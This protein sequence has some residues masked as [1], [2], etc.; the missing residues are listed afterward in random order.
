MTAFTN[1]QVN[2]ELLTDE[3]GSYI[4]LEQKNDYEDPPT[5]YLHPWQLRATCEHFGII[6]SEQGSANSI[7]SLERLLMT[8]RDRI[9]TLHD[10]LCNNSDHKHA[11]LTVELT[12]ATAT[13]D[14][15]NEF[16]H[17]L[18]NPEALIPPPKI[19]ESAKT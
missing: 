6:A 14:I 16:C 5:V 2:A 12:Y 10:Y 19:Q 18:D 8:L 9:E 4:S 13:I 1:Y 3:K 17:D 15:A 7:A 11:D